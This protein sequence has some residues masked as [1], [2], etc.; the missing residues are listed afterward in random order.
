MCEYEEVKI[1]F[2]LVCETSIYEQHKPR[3]PL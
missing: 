3:N 1:S 2:N